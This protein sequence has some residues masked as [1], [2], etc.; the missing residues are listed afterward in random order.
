MRKKLG[1]IFGIVAVLLFGI[2]FSKNYIIKKVLENKLTEINKGKVDIGKVDFSP[3]SKKIIIEDIDITSRKNGMK[4]FISIGKFETDYD[5]YFKEKKILVNKADFTEIEFMTERKTNGSTGFVVEE[6]NEV[7]V[8]TEENLDEKKQSSLQDLEELIKARAMVNQITLKNMLENQYEKIEKLLKE[9]ESY[10][11]EKLENIEKTPEYM[12]LKKNFEKI[13]KE[14]N[15]LK[16]LRMEKEFKNMGKA[17]KVLSKE[18]LQNRKDMQEDFKNIT[19]IDEMNKEL[20]KTVNEL[21]GRGEFVVTDLDS[22]INYYLN[23]IYGE[24]IEKMVIKYRDV[25]REIELRKEEDAKLENKWEIFAEDIVIKSKL[26]GIELKGEIKNISSRLSRN[27]EN[28]EIYLGADSNIS[29][30]EAYGYID[31][32]KI[33][34]KFDVNIS[35]FNFEDLKDMEVLNRYVTTGEASLVKEVIL[36]KDDIDIRGDVEIHDMS[37][38]GEEIIEKLNIDAPLLKAMVIPILKDLSSGNVHYEYNSINGNLLIKSDLSAEIMDILND[39]NG[40]VKKKII[41]DML[42]EGKE[43]IKKYNLKFDKENKSTLGELQDKLDEKS[44]YLDRVQ[45]ILDKYNLNDL[46]DK[47]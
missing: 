33:Q 17:F 1:I 8:N 24:K 34:G 43:E 44:K 41:E 12:I 9:K 30:G 3:F 14:K 2:Y 45:D 21:V 37:L 6:P 18:F 7:E 22:I 40:A 13:S 25:M 38:N 36:G 20:E 28:I 46:L 26:Y 32:N 27:K 15:P 29:H 19:S 23:E 11:K 35:N 10:W 31:L 5:I 39:E 42:K 47:F 16:L 4:N